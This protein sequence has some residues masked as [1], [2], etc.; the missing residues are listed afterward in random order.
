MCLPSLQIEKAS[1]IL[2]FA[3]I[4]KS[5]PIPPKKSDFH[6]CSPESK[7]LHVHLPLSVDICFHS[8]FFDFQRLDESI[9]I[10]SPK[11]F[12]QIIHTPKKILC[13]LALKN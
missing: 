5:V 13:F 3:S 7:S 1:F 12:I 2:R 6:I 4:F 9:E 10:C 11:L 8:L